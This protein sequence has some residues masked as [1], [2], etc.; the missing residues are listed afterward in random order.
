MTNRYSE[1]EAMA[2]RFIDGLPNLKM[3]IFQ[4]MMEFVSWDDE[5]NSQLNGKS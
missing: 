2:H 1:L 4:K 5:G 3:V